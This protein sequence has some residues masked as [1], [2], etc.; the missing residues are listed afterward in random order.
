[1]KF[2]KFVKN[3]GR[4]RLPTVFWKLTVS[5]SSI[6]KSTDKKYAVGGALDAKKAWKNQFQCFVLPHLGFRQTE[7][8]RSCDLR[9][10]H[11]NY[12]GDIVI[13]RD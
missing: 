8:G 2:V 5:C 4:G 9:N 6:T 11:K 1:M 10:I 7:E 12:V 3:F 13:N